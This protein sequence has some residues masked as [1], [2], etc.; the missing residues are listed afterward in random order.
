MF[1]LVTLAFTPAQAEMYSTWENMEIDKCASAW[2]IKRFVDKQAVFRF[3][4]K[5]ELIT[6]G[7]PFDVPEA[8]IRRY[9]NLSAFEY[10][11]KKYQLTDPAVKKIARIIHDIEINYWGEKQIPDSIKINDEFKKIA[12]AAKTPDECLKQGFV[13]FD[14]L[15]STSQKSSN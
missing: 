15:Y 12:D 14:R 5:G 9:H 4:P 7:I 8:Q 13:F 2:L 1:V 11:V 6:Q 3:V 10:I